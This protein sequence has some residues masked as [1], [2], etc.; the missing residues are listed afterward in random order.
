[1]HKDNLLFWFG[2]FPEEEVAIKTREGRTERRKEEP[3]GVEQ[4]KA[5]FSKR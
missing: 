1:M 5:C 2:C 4:N 3:S